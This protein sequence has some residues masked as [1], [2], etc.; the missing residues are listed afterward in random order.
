MSKDSKAKV[1]EV[2]DWYEHEIE[3]GISQ[4]GIDETDI[5]DGYKERFWNLIGG[6]RALHGEIYEWNEARE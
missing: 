6:L 3:D 4:V 1:R 5:P 2:L